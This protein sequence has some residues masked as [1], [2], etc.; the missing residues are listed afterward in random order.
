MYNITQLPPREWLSRDIKVLSRC[1]I[2]QSELI[3]VG[4]VRLGFEFSSMSLLHQVYESGIK[5]L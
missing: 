5:T 4:G 3:T 1:E 2:N